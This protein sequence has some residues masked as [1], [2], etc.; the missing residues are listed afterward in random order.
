[1]NCSTG[2]KVLPEMRVLEVVDL[3][4]DVAKIR[5]AKGGSCC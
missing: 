3:S 2:G 5:S 4:G 1:M